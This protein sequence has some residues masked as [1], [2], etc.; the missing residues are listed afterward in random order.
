MDLQNKSFN[1]KPSQSEKSDVSSL[2]C[3]LGPL[4]PHLADENIGWDEYSSPFRLWWAKIPFSGC[5]QIMF[6]VKF[7]AR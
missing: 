5:V 3:D 6:R 1:D 7:S 4:F 2:L